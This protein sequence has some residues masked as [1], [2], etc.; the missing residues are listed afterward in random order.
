M[1]E[2]FCGQAHDTEAEFQSRLV[3]LHPELIARKVLKAE[4]APLCKS[5]VRNAAK[6]GR[7]PEG[8]T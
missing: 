5:C 7:L 4:A 6:A 2:A 8:L 1:H 3:G